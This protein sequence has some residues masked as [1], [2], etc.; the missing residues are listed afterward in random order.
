MLLPKETLQS[1]IVSRMVFVQ[2]LLILIASHDHYNNSQIKNSKCA[3]RE[4]NRID[5]FLLPYSSLDWRFESSRTDQSALTHWRSFPPGQKWLEE[6]A[7]E[8]EK[9]WFCYWIN[10]N[11]SLLGDHLNLYKFSPFLM[12]FDSSVNHWIIEAMNWQKLSRHQ[13]TKQHTWSIKAMINFFVVLCD[14]ICLS[15]TSHIVKPDN[16]QRRVRERG[17]DH[18]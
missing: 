3:Y 5:W 10:S 4:V 7:R 16:R 1:V 12:K 11:C 14:K 6:S 15:P 8:W 13:I 17:S 9:V 2:L 18:A